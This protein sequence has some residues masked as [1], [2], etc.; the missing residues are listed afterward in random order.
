MDGYQNEMERRVWQRVLGGQR[1][2][3]QSLSALVAGIWSDAGAYLAL[4]RRLTGP[5][6]ELLRQLH[7]QKLAQADCLRGI[8]LLTTGSKPGARAE[9]APQ[10][11]VEV[12]LRRCYGGEMR[13]LAEFEARQTDGEYGPVFA[14]LAAQTR[15]HCRMILQLMGS[16]SE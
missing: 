11:P 6:K 16:L 8:C 9:P 5:E 4:S 2:A 1:D 15:E 7:G 12:T 13:R 14:C 10:E 3:G